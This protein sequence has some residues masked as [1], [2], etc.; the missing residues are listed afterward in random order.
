M[1]VISVRLMCSVMT[2]LDG[3]AFSAAWCDKCY[4]MI[5]VLIS[6]IFMF[7]VLMF[8]VLFNNWNLNIY[9]KENVK[10]DCT[11]LGAIKAESL[12]RTNFHFVIL[13]E[14]NTSGRQSVG[15]LSA[16]S[17]GF[18]LRPL[19]WE[20]LKNSYLIVSGSSISDSILKFH[21]WM[22]R[23][24]CWIILNIT[25]VEDEHRFCFLLLERLAI[26]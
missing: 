9:A 11:F 20:K 5:T 16:S 3:S 17:P 13:T 6:I 24:T 26:V 8:Y 10:I 21:I 23:V 1:A 4:I 12:L 2:T 7:Y 19:G 25:N 22:T 15:T 14:I 18:L